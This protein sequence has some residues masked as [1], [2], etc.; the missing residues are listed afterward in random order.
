MEL[1]ELPAWSLST[2]AFRFQ[3]D[4]SDS[5][6][7]RNKLRAGTEEKKVKKR[8]SVTH[9]ETRWHRKLDPWKKK[10]ERFYLFTTRKTG[11]NPVF[12][13][14][15]PWFHPRRATDYLAQC[16]SL[17]HILQGVIYLSVG[18]RHIHYYGLEV[19]IFFPS[20]FRPHFHINE[21]EWRAGESSVSPIPSVFSA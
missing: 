19:C 8:R 13:T 18:V 21:I 11:E 10:K 20:F 5:F 16:I 3:N 6:P 2:K 14:F 12:V 4:Q 15:N 17:E 7:T 9:G 1:N